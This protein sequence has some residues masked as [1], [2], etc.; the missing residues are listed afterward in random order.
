MKDW[1]L[2]AVKLVVDEGRLRLLSA[3]ERGRE[4][5]TCDTAEFSGVRVKMSGGGK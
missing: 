2:W 4:R 5:V 3:E 1:V